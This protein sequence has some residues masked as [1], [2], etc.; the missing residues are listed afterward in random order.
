MEIWYFYFF[1]KL[2]IKS[3]VIRL[4][5]NMIKSLTGQ[6][7]RKELPK[8]N[9]NHSKKETNVILCVALLSTADFKI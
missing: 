3:Q 5:K 4:L 8:P 2:I 1:Q 6:W 7:K 9:T